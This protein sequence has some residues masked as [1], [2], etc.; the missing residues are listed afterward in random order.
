M[1]IAG[2]KGHAK[3]LLNVIREYDP[4]LPM[5]SFDDILVTGGFADISPG[6]TIGESYTKENFTCIGANAMIPL[7]I[8]TGTNV[9]IAA[10]AVDIKNTTYNT[11][12]AGNP[13]VIK[14]HILPLNF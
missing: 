12:V 2:V 7:H 1:V 9:M 3:E 4:S 10:A 8:Q 6:A 11:M 14:K 13:A 5:F